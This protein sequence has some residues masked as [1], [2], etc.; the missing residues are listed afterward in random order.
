MVRSVSTARSRDTCYACRSIA[1]SSRRA[2]RVASFHRAYPS[3]VRF[4]KARATSESLRREHLNVTTPF[5]IKVAAVEQSVNV[6]QPTHRLAL[7]KNSSATDRR[8]RIAS[9][10]GLR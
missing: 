1:N 3:Y 10:P 8:I 4:L 6:F 7:V 2:C 5:A 9:Q